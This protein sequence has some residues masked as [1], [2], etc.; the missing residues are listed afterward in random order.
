MHNP[1][2]SLMHSVLNDARAVGLL[3][4]VTS[5]FFFPG[6]NRY[7]FLRFARAESIYTLAQCCSGIE[8]AFECACSF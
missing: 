4:S 3:R 1:R 5:Q 8:K 2:A 7:S 6:M